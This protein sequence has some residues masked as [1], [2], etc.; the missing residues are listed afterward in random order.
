MLPVSQQDNSG[1]VGVHGVVQGFIRR[2]AGQ[3][4]ILSERDKQGI[5]VA[6]RLRSSAMSA[7]LSG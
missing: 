1:E 2:D 7:A 5:E 3:C 6:H 4:Q